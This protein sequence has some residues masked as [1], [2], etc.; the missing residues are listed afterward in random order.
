MVRWVVRGVL[1]GYGGNLGC[2][3][4]DQKAV[5]HTTYS[6]RNKV[7][8]GCQNENDRMYSKAGSSNLNGWRSGAK[9][10]NSSHYI[11]IKSSDRK[12]FVCVHIDTTDSNSR[13]WIAYNFC[14]YK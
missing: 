9:S 1:V 10:S 11:E 6:A 14:A 4:K 12:Y 3:F 13:W 2:N 8:C 5:R 7:C